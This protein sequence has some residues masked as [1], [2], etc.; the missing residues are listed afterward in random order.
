MHRQLQTVSDTCALNPAA[1][2]SGP[3]IRNILAGD[4]F[5]TTFNA[6]VKDDVE[7]IQ[8]IIKEWTSSEQ[9][10]LILTTGGTGFGVRD[11][12]P[13]VSRTSCPSGRSSR[14]L[15]RQYRLSWND[16]LQA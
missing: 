16:M 10:D 9:V 8:V 5:D 6:I 14:L 13:E 4:R 15:V 11:K 7:D 3:T 12:T 1:D 2:K